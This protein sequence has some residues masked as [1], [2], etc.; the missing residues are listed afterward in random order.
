MTK[1]IGIVCDSV[2]ADKFRKGLLKDGFTIEHD[3]E[4]G[5][6]LHVF[7]IEVQES[8]YAEMVKRVGETVKRLEFE[9]IHSN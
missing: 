3:K 4:S 9:F 6:D 5:K 7:R 8:D 2:K 1:K